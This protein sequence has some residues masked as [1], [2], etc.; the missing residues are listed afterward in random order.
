M[1]TE[2]QTYNLAVLQD[3]VSQ[4]SIQNPVHRGSEHRKS[5]PPFPGAPPRAAEHKPRGH[6]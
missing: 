2:L 5:T 4:D 6:P 3:Q 1:I